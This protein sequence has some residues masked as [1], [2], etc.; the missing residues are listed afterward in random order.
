MLM[1]SM[2]SISIVICTFNNAASLQKTLSS[3]AALRIPKEVSCEVCLVNNNSSDNTAAVCEAA[4]TGL[5]LP[6]RYFFEAKQGLSHARNRGIAEAAGEFIIFTDDDVVVPADWVEHYSNAITTLGAD[7]VFGRILPEWYGPP[8]D[9]YCP[10]MQPAYALLDYGPN[11]FVVN[12]RGREFY[13]ANFGCKKALLR[14]LGG[15]NANLGR[16]AG[17][18]FIGEERE[19]FLSLMDRAAKIIYDPA[20]FVHH[21]IAEK[22]KKKSYLRKYYWDIAVSLVYM[23][24]L[25]RKRSILGIPLYKLRECLAF[26]F[27]ALLRALLYLVSFN[28]KRL[29]LLEL[30]ARTILRTTWIYA[31]R[32]FAR[33]LPQARSGD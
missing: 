25:R 11:L 22:R 5:P 19:L 7:A 31:Q 28:G 26:Y 15:F 20:I 24:D 6:V 13:G 17:R 14:E 10:D 2:P 12:D 18:L 1:Q 33:L 29:F 21:I 30:R 4:R 3:I 32:P 23:A 9:F 16:T 8:P 27:P